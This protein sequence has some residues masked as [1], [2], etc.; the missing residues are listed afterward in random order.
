MGLMRI[1]WLLLLSLARA[2]ALGAGEL[3][4]YTA[5]VSRAADALE[6]LDAAGRDASGSGVGATVRAFEL[7]Q[8]LFEN[9]A[10]DANQVAAAGFFDWLA[11]LLDHPFATL[12]YNACVFLRSLLV[13]KDKPRKFTHDLADRMFEE[14]IVDR[15]I[16][17]ASSS[18]DEKEKDMATYALMDV[19]SVVR[20]YHVPKL[21]H[22]GALDVVCSAVRTVDA[23][24][25]ELMVKALEAAKQ[26][27]YR[28]QAGRK[29][30]AYARGGGGGGADPAQM[31][32]MAQMAQLT[33][34]MGAS[35][36]GMGM[37]MGGGPDMGAML[38]AM[39]GAGAGDNIDAPHELAIHAQLCD[40]WDN[41]CKVFP[42]GEQPRLDGP[43]DDAAREKREAAVA[44]AREEE[45]AAHAE[46][47]VALREQL[48]AAGQGMRAA[49]ARA[50]ASEGA[51][52]A[53]LEEARR[54]CEATTM[55]AAEAARKEE[56]ER[57]YAQ[58]AAGL[59]RAKWG[60][61]GVVAATK[62][63]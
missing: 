16:A 31:A 33:Q 39:Q 27:D 58:S 45:R 54:E 57:I 5:A 43:E 40:G 18:T 2:R 20:D 24:S 61:R 29:L 37:G 21:V 50:A 4:A 60:R 47:L 63:S 8:G 59:L 46:E 3:E 30:E 6:S 26:L 25:A 53:A 41:F 51:R 23:K 28:D 48:D 22:N 9:D 36:G 14:G 55:A 34:M 11:R 7:S 10:I 32:Q 52:G 13:V 12:R 35:M 1:A 49:E 56:R 15:V 44:A 38:Q 19:V 62:D 42:C 17:L